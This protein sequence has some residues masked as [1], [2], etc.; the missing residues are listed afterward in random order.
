MQQTQQSSDEESSDDE[1]SEE[2][3]DFIAP[4]AEV[5]RDQMAERERKRKRR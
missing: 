5:E 2:M 1:D 3:A 4:D